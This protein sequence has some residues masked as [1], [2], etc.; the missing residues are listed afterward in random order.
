MSIS[1]GAAQSFIEGELGGPTSEEESEVVTA[2]AFVTLC[3]N[4]PEAVVLLLINLGSNAVYIGLQDDVSETKGIYL[5]ANGGS[6]SMAIRDDYTLPTRQWF[7]V[8]PSGAST[9]YVLRLR[10]YALTSP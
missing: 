2:A 10:R 3:A 6:V 9:V 5:A 8:S 7:A 1:V 4:D